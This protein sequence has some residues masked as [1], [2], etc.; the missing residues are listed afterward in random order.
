[1][2]RISFDE[3]ERRELYGFFADMSNPFYSVTFNLDVTE[4]YEYVKTRGLS[5]YYALTYLV[6]RAVNSV[7]A[8][9]FTMRDGTPVLLDERIPSFTDLKKDAETFHIVTMPC[10]GSI[11]DFC[12]LAKKRSAEQTSFIDKSSE[13]DE[14][15]FIS[16][17]PW[18]ELTAMTN[19][20]NFVKDDA[21][22]RI[23]WGKYHEENGRKILGMSIELNHAFADGK[24]IGDFAAALRNLIR[25]LSK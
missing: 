19:E 20:R 5:F 1:M 18:I 4:L 15:I 25:E 2:Q 8:L 24:H 11:E 14:L 9:R 13:S 12:A 7:R 17:L 3:W 16:C 22:P 10:D 23:A 21:I 6:T